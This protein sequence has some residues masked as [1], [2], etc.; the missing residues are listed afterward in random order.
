[1]CGGRM[2]DAPCSRV[3]HV[4]RDAPQGRPSVKGDFLSVVRSIFSCYYKLPFPIR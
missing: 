3:G 4:F 2:L 1:M